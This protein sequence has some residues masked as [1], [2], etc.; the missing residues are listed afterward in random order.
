[1]Q[2]SLRSSEWLLVSSL[3]LLLISFFAI[4]RLHEHRRASQ[5]HILSHKLHKP[6]DVVIEG[7]VAKP[8]V[9]SV[10]RGTV[11]KD[12]LK[13]SRPKRFA[14]LRVLDLEQSV[15]EPM[16]IVVSELSVIRVFLSGAVKIPVELEVPAG[17]RVCQ[18][19]NKINCEPLADKGFFKS[20]R[21][22]KDGEELE[23]PWVRS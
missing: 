4:A 17:T 18:L 3:L 12:V 6:M 7:A 15:E 10:L 20:R 5:L 2:K 14:D 13:K 8:G 9:Y 19:K 22:L 21:M 11:L 16:R 23:I 1:M